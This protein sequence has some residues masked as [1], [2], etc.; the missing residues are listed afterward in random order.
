MRTS[1]LDWGSTLF[2]IRFL[3]PLSS[4][5]IHSLSSFALGSMN[6]GNPQTLIEICVLDY[7]RNMEKLRHTRFAVHR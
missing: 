1:E 5:Q 2:N 7:D 6:F 3:V 4:A